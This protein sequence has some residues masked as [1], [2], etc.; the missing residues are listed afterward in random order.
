MSGLRETKD[1]GH[2]DEQH[3][4]KKPKGKWEGGLHAQ[5]RQQNSIRNRNVRPRRREIAT[6]AAGRNNI[7]ETQAKRSM[8][9]RL[10]HAV[11]GMSALILPQTISCARAGRGAPASSSRFDQNELEDGRE[12]FF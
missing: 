8:S 5:S 1:H 2:G 12:S 3:R 10:R 6:I 9:A 4:E 11:A 7:A